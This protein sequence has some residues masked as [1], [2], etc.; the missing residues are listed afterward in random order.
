MKRV[1]FSALLGALLS[2]TVACNN[3]QN[4]LSPEMSKSSS[5]QGIQ[6]QAKSSTTSSS[7]QTPQEQVPPVS[8]SESDK[9][10]DLLKKLGPLAGKAGAP[11]ALAALSPD[12]LQTLLQNPVGLAQLGVSAEQVQQALAGRLPIPKELDPAILDNIISTLP[13]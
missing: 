12:E 3:P 13:K 9:L 7:D 1:L 8:S 6:Q 11:D 4:K 10:N 2:T 5:S